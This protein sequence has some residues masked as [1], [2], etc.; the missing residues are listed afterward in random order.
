[1]SC[2]SLGMAGVFFFFCFVLFFRRFV[3]RFTEVF[4]FVCF[5]WG[6]AVRI[7][8]VGDNTQLCRR[9]AFLAVA[10]GDTKCRR[11][12]PNYFPSLYVTNTEK[13]VLLHHSI[14]R[15]L[16]FLFF[17]EFF[18][19]FFCF[20]LVAN[21]EETRQNSAKETSARKRTN[22]PNQFGRPVRRRKLG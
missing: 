18:A 12:N 20:T 21:F 9:G 11:K 17:L 22:K 16:L 10:A 2:R 1:M 6:F 19:F 15:F 5:F 7:R 3:T 13:Q 8:S 14:L 4:F